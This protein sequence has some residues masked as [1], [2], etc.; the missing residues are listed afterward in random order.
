MFVFTSL[1]QAGDSVNNGGGLA[2][3]NFW[4][5]YSKLEGIYQSC[6][7]SSE[8]LLDLDEKNLLR[9]L[10]AT[11]SEEKK[12]VEQIQFLSGQSENFFLDGNRILIA[13]TNFEVGGV[14]WIN[15]DLIYKKSQSGM[16]T[17]Y[18]IFE[19]LGILTEQLLSHQ[20]SIDKAHRYYIAMIIENFYEKHQ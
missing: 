12:T 15:R 13:R 20:S 10:L 3:Q 9:S 11:V 4:F 19:A 7:D 1:A 17:A 14:I 16:V 8:C 2:E 6:L 5:A 18:T